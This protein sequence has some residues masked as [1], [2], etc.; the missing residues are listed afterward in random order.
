MVNNKARI[1]LASVIVGMVF[2]MLV[3]LGVVVI[4]VQSASASPGKGDVTVSNPSTADQQDV[5]A[6]DTPPP[7]HTCSPT[8][9]PT[10]PPYTPHPTRTPCSACPTR[11]PFPCPWCTP[12]PTRTTSPSDD[13]RI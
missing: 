10:L 1:Q 2:M 11:T 3:A 6:P 12:H 8:W 4:S 13:P 7:W 5:A 9:W